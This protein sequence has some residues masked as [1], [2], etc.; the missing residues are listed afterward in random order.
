VLTVVHALEKAPKHGQ[1]DG[2]RVIPAVSDKLAEFMGPAS[3]GIDLR[4]VVQYGEPVEVILRAAIERQ[5]D[6]LVL[7][8]HRR[9]G[10]LNRFMWPTAYGVVR[11]A[12]CPVLTVRSAR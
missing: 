6:Y 8:V 12:S 2:G 10:L 11:E 7:G 5:A 4:Y 3:D 9:P 1:D